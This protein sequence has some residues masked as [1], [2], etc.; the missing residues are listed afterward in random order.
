VKWSVGIQAEGDRV[1]S[2]EEV[3]ELADA[4]AHSSGVASGI[5]TNR[6]GATL[7]VE[8][9]SRDEAIEIATAEF[10]RA[11]AKA[12]LPAFPIVR[13]EAVGEDEDAE[14][15]GV[16]ARDSGAGDIRAGDIR[17]GDSGGGD[18]RAGDSGTGDSGTGDSGTGDTRGGNTGTGD[19]RA[20]DIGGG[21]IRGGN[22]GT[23][24]V[25]G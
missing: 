2:R 19:T 20:G 22:T 17:A 6:Y 16:G 24:D 10:T 13:I 15:E 25:A 5:G 14:D 4:V 21:D 9:R 11:A 1:I 7:V 23:G 3:V 18:I 8:A 12:G